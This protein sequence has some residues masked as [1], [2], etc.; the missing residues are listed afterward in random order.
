MKKIILG[1]KIDDINIDRAVNT[2]EGWLK[3]PGKYY[4]VTPNPEFL[5][6]AQDNQEFKNI[7]NGA[8][9]AIPDGVGLKLA[10]I[11]NT[12]A[13]TDLM[14]SLVELAAEKTYTIGLLGGK[15]GIAERTAECLK[16]KYPE[17]KI[18]FLAARDFAIPA[19]NILFV[20]FGHPKQEYWIAENLDKIPVKVAMGVGGAFDYISGAVP[21]APGWI[22][23]LGFEWLFRL[24][25]QPWRIKRQISL[26]RYL[27]MLI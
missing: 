8:D 12:I 4:I 20:A 23:G 16:R 13:G 19:T 10:G 25:V 5:V 17:L 1:V 27:L 24:V 11:K 18:S 15:E 26:I 2:V 7:L 9:L 6:T 14:E 3:K 22:R 21:R